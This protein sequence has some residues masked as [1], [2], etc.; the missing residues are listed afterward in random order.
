MCGIGGF[1]LPHG[2]EPGKNHKEILSR[3]E[4][5]MY[6]RGPDASG[7]QT[8]DSAGFV[9]TRLSI[10]DLDA[11]SNQP[12]ESA[13]WILS[14]NGEIYNFKTLRAD[15]GTDRF[16]T[17]SDT[18]VLLM[19]LQ[20]WGVDETLRRC[21]GMYAFLAYHKKSQIFYAVR[22][23]LGI[24]PLFM[25]K[26]KNEEWY[27]ASTP[28]ALVAALPDQ[29]WKECKAA[30]AS[31][32]TLGASFTT[33]SVYSGIEKVKPAHYVEIHP[34]GSFFQKRYWTPQYQTH[35]TMED[36]KS[37]I[38]EYE[39]S[40]VKSALFLSGGVDSTFLASVTQ[41]LD[42][43]HLTSSERGYAQAV[44]A[45][46]GRPLVEVAPSV[47]D[48]LASIEDVVH[49]YG[50]PLMS[51]GI[52]YT[53]AHALKKNGY[54]MAVSANGADELFHGYSRTP[55][56]EYTSAGFPLHEEPT[57]RWFYHQLAHIFRDSRNFELEAYDAFVPTIA[58]MAYD[59]VRQYRLDG[60]PE[61]AQHRWF[62]LMTY[63]LHD[64]NPTLDAASMA[65]SVEV[66]LPFLDHRIV[67]GVLSWPAQTFV[68]AQ[69]GRK[70]PLKEA[71]AADFPQSFF[72]RS[73]V[74]FSIDEKILA[75]IEQASASTFDLF[76]QQG[77]IRMRSRPGFGY[78]ERDKIYLRNCSLAYQLWKKN[79]VLLMKEQV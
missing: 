20:H 75:P 40:D 60:F 38:R 5:Q 42:Y 77:F 48:Y 56:P 70:T 34:D 41:K 44:A 22:D 27:F 24:K 55:M 25:T 47:E 1:F 57:A 51:C 17:T 79:S 23:R 63:V 7:Q 18:E 19:A 54:K 72:N 58:E 46:Y 16:K 3:L 53:I 43:F 68:T 64:L 37:I 28:A 9:H 26:L 2:R 39:V 49:F 29:D 67:E 6:R 52:P 11:R 35:F 33:S 15:L 66:R 21:A 14:Y 10:L 30:V 61:S 59:A 8:Y 45:K 36:M 65:N 4:K 31:Y 71:L 32:F 73:K 76:Q 50:E 13:D 12:M 69:W 74:G 78:F 62:E